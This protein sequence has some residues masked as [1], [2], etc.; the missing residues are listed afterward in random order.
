MREQ[1]NGPHAP[2]TQQSVISSTRFVRKPEQLVGFNG[3]QAGAGC[4]PQFG[5][6]LG[7]SLGLLLLL[8]NVPIYALNNDTPIKD[9]KNKPI[10]CLNKGAVKTLVGV[11]ETELAGKKLRLTLTPHSEFAGSY[12]GSYQLDGKKYWL[13]GDEEDGLLT[14]EESADEVDVS[15]VWTGKIATPKCAREISGERN[16][17]PDANGQTAAPQ[18]FIMRYLQP[19]SVRTR[20]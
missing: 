1:T 9:N 11:Y 17:E 12:E 7:L 13:A 14:L 15:A 2:M 8:Q 4:R 19:L 6:C 3:R 18:A 16:P 5:L 20:K 10:K